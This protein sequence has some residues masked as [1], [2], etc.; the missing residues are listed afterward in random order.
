MVMEEV[1]LR[2]TLGD[3]R[4]L[5]LNGKRNENL[6]LEGSGDILVLIYLKVPF[7]IKDKDVF[8]FGLWSWVFF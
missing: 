4:K 5:C 3:T 1:V 6:L 8:P 7:A 2:D